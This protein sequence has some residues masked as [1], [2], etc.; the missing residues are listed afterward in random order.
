MPRSTYTAS[1]GTEFIKWCGLLINATSLEVQADYTR[2][3]GAR[4]ATAL[5]LPSAKVRCL[6]VLRLSYQ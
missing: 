3:A 6:L 4:L 1:D 5:T 2:Y